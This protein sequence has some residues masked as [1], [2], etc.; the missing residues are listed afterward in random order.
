LLGAQDLPN[1]NV[2]KLADRYELLEELG[3]GGAGVVFRARQLSLNRTVA[4]KLLLNSQLLDPAEIERFRKEAETIAQLRHPNIV[5]VYEVGE[6]SGQPWFSMDLIE[7]TNLLV[8]A[9]D[10]SI[11]PKQAAPLV[12]KIALAIALF[13][14]R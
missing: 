3:R 2:D 4:L 13:F 6:D 5:A 7:G 9:R 12:R 10:A 14:E 11:G 8:L 1:E